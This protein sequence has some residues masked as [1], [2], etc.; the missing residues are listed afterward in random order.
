MAINEQFSE[1]LLGLRQGNLSYCYVR[2]LL[3]KKYPENCTRMNIENNP[4]HPSTQKNNNNK[5]SNAQ[6]NKN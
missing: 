3:N 1:T 6:T 4:Q 2:A 5:Q